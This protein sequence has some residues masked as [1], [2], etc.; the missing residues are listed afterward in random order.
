MLLMLLQQELPLS[1]LL[2]RQHAAAA[3]AAAVGSR[4]CSKGTE[5]ERPLFFCSRPYLTS[6]MPL[7]QGA[8]LVWGLNSS[9]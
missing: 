4:G 3:A 2:Q 1:S 5:T 9:L 7:L 8:P 6:R